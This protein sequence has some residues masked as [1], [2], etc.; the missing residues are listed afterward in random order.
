VIKDIDRNI[1]QLLKTDAKFYAIHVSPSEK[2]LQA[3][4]STEQ[5]QLEAMKRYI[6]EVFIPEYDKNLNK[7][8]SAEEI[9]FYG[10]IYLNRDSS[11]NPLNMHCH[12]IVSHKEQSNIVKINPLTNHRNTKKGVITGGFDRTVLFENIEK[13][14]NK[15]FG[16]NRQLPKRSSITI[17]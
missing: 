15:L 1:R 6:R 10:K 9:K 13:G 4:G 12:L 7:G 2:E 14:S 3:M 11:D 17:L 5:E 16:Y 8:L